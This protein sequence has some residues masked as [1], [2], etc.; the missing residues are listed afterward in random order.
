MNRRQFLQVSQGIAG[1]MIMGGCVANRGLSASK[2]VRFGLVTDLHFSRNS[3]RYGQ[4]VAK[5]HDAIQVFNEQKPDF[6]IELG[7]FK[8]LGE[9][10]EQ[11]LAFLDEIE[12]EFQAF[13]GDVYH[14]LGNHDEDSISKQDFLQH[15]V[16]AGAAKGKNFYSFTVEVLKFIVLDANYN[17]D[18]T[19][20]DRGNFDWTKAFIPQQQLDWLAQELD[21]RQPVV[22]FLH[23][24]LDLTQRQHG[25][26]VGNAE[27]VIAALEKSGNVLAVFQG[28]HHR[29]SYQFS[30][31]IHYYTMKAMGEGSL[32][33]NSFAMVEITDNLDIFID[34]YF[35]CE[36][37][38]LKKK[39]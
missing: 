20:Y 34:G 2:T 9:N 8:D 3:S 35:N 39:Q 36:D 30:G 23:Q 16:N 25:V 6:I 26:C 28:H 10:K 19:D 21:T 38:V 15:T 4:S 32:P 5:L 11:T 24:L 22:I 33:N 31:G 29:G 14:V 1:M 17:E 18:M 27:E 7:D 12:A 37:L 13:N